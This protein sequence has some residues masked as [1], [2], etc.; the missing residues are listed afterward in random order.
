MIIKWIICGVLWFA[1]TPVNGQHSQ[2]RNEPVDSLLEILDTSRSNYQVTQLTEDLLQ[3][4]DTTRPNPTLY[5]IYRENG[6]SQ[7]RSGNF[8]RA[9][10]SQQKASS[11]AQQLQDSFF[12]A[13]SAYSI[14][15]IQY[16][17]KLFDPAREQ[18]QIAINIFAALDS[19]RWVAYVHNAFGLLERE[20]RNWDKALRYYQQ[21]YDLL[22]ELDQKEQASVPLNNMGDVYFHQSRFEKA[23][24]TFQASMVLARQQGRLDDVAVAHLNIGQ[25]QRELGHFDPAL[26]EIRAGMQ[27]AHAN[28]FNRIAALGLKDLAETFEKMKLPDSALYYLENFVDLQDSL[29]QQENKARLEELYVAYETQKARSDAENRQREINL[30][31]QEKR[32]DYLTDYFIISLLILALLTS[33]FFFVRNRMKR[34][35]A[36]SELRNQKLEAEQMRRELEGKQKDLTNLALEIARKNEL[37]TK[38]NEALAKIQQLHLPNDKQQQIRKLIHYNA[39]QLRINEDLEE[40][41]VNIEQ[42]NADFFEK[43]SQIAPDLTPAEKQLCALLRLNL[44]TKEI[45]AIRNI[46]PKSVE[47]ARYRLRKKLPIEAEDDIYGFVQGI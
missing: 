12:I 39:Q 4:L 28:G 38:T 6:L 10:L 14:G 26:S 17:Q 5:R 45:A 42:V 1:I 44:G 35:L 32:L 37:F 41:Q 16:N 43:L 23:L 20:L 27:L 36:E 7:L 24:L 40:L 30:L 29:Q 11:I 15:S 3:L 25:A 34:K 31:R 22:G 47:M 9:L 33:T 13:Q 2:D 46:S 8:H 21:A 18:Y 19:L